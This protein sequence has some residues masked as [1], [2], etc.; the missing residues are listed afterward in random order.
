MSSPALFTLFRDPPHLAAFEPREVETL[1]A[2]ADVRPHPELM[3]TASDGPFMRVLRHLGQPGES[4]PDR[5]FFEDLVKLVALRSAYPALLGALPALAQPTEGWAAGARALELA[6]QSG[7]EQGLKG[8]WHALFEEV[9]ELDDAAALDT[10]ATALLLQPP[11][12]SEILPQEVVAFSKVAP[13]LPDAA[14]LLSS[15]LYPGLSTASEGE[16]WRRLA[17][18]TF[19]HVPGELREE[20]RARLEL[21]RWAAERCVGLRSFAKLNALERQWPELARMLRTDRATL[22]ALEGEALRPD[23]IAPEHQAVWQRYA[24]DERLRR[25][26]VLRPLVTDIA[27]A[28][29]QQYFTIS[30]SIAPAGDL[31]GPGPTEA[32]APLPGAGAPAR[33]DYV[34]LELTL[35]LVG[36]DG[37]DLPPA[38]S[39]S[40]E[41]R[42][43]RITVSL[44]EAER[45]G[46]FFTH[47]A[48]VPWNELGHAASALRPDASGAP[49]A[50]ALLTR[51]VLQRN[52][53][54]SAEAELRRVGTRMWRWVF[55]GEVGTCMRELHERGA[56]YRLLLRIPPA[57][58]GL[59]WETLYLE[60]DRMFLAL[61]QRYSVV[62]YTGPSPFARAEIA[63][64]LR[65]LVL[66][67]NPPDT[68]PLNLDGELATL[69][70]ALGPMLGEERVSLSVLRGKQA[71][72]DGLQWALRAFRPH[73]FHF[74]GHGV[75][76][77][78]EHEGALV[79]HDDQ[80]GRTRL[81]PAVD[82]ATLLRDARISL[83]CLN[84]CD[85]GTAAENDAVTG[86]A[87][88]LV[89]A[90]VPAVVAT[91][92]AITD[93]A[94]LLFTRELYR[95]FAEGYPLEVALAEARK[96]L[97]V[98]RMDWS[99]YAL[100]ASTPN[101]D[102]LTFP[103]DEMLRK[104]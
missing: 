40:G 78:I 74:T 53:P 66:L 63:T 34:D 7:K 13:D 68:P 61:T 84:A 100:F 49:V 97:S 22:K 38:Q 4:S 92:R 56:P 36:P 30:Q 25:F 24:R 35:A 12:L 54:R 95:G 76:D 2:I 79:L 59:P 81:V 71:T 103:R 93:D 75:F 72:I 29:V 65:I 87:G 98:E 104:A 91:V 1:A 101:L 6:L 33:I 85:T 45:P 82:I 83:A 70:E 9:R 69:R 20:I 23:S 43:A 62:R 73:V 58:A 15:T 8:G 60:Q 37:S 3:L 80:D 67:S 39:G 31:G 46:T 77:R 28:E 96:R 27:P 57:L 14:S 94:G 21:R 44:Q 89:H 16:K 64:P 5:I 86:V 102:A 51:G 11:R 41:L 90:G 17:Q 42:T 52:T 55:A 26:L 50:Q 10:G 99:A 88:S 47:T 32:A 19:D 48:D 18:Y